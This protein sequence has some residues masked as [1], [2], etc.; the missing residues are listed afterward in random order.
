M[1][2]SQRA[3]NQGEAFT[4]CADQSATRKVTSSREI[5][6]KRTHLERESPAGG[7]CHYPFQ[8]ENTQQPA[9]QLR[10]AGQRKIQGNRKGRITCREGEYQLPG[11][12]YG[13]LGILP[14]NTAKTVEGPVFAGL[15]ATINFNLAQVSVSSSAFGSKN[16][17]KQATINSHCR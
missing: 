13:V 9:R 7:E 5:A 6:T 12:L 3:F 16:E 15:Q 10:G 8:L 2:Y 1:S 17:Q 11:Y 4:G 14:P